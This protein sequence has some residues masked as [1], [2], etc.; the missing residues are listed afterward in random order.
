[1]YY[2]TYT[3]QITLTKLDIADLYVR[4]VVISIT[5]LAWYMMMH[6]VLYKKR[7]HIKKPI[8][9]PISHLQV[10]L[11]NVITFLYFWYIF[12][13]EIDQIISSYITSCYVEVWSSRQG[14]TLLV[15]QFLWCNSSMSFFLRN[16]KTNF[17]PK[18]CYFIEFLDIAP[19]FVFYIFGER[20]WNFI[21]NNKPHKH[22][23]TRSPQESRQPKRTQDIAP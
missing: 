15:H 17:L 5:N 9:I 23:R 1:M 20:N 6:H 11:P 14:N 10:V 8:W 21:R 13:V 3:E 2:I 12:L 22:L 7:H 16:Q 19:W 4:N 18:I